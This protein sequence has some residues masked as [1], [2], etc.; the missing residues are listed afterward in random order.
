MCAA[1]HA[2]PTAR[3]HVAS[4]R[5]ASPRQPFC[6]GSPP[7]AHPPPPPRLQ[8]PFGG[9]LIAFDR[10]ARVGITSAVATIGASVPD[11]ASDCLA[12]LLAGACAAALTTPLDVLVTHAATTQEAST[13][14]RGRHVAV[15]SPTPLEIGATLVREEGVLVLTRGIGGRIVFHACL[16][17]TFFGLYEGFR[18]VLEAHGL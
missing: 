3:E 10:E 9:L 16:A 12:G 14:V 1:A 5:A 2:H 7:A 8:V 13:I 17:G 4:R 6:W 11:S 18:R 15:P